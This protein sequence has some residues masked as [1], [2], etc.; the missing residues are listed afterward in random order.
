MGRADEVEALMQREDERRP[1]SRELAKALSEYAALLRDTRP[2]FSGGARSQ[3]D[4][5]RCA[6]LVEAATRLLASDGGDGVWDAMAHAEARRDLHDALRAHRE[7][8][9]GV[10]G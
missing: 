6:P 2:R 8:E 4:E 9:G 10:G 5:D 3:E 7:R 1:L